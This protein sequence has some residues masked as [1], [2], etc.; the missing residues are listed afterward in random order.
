MYSNIIPWNFEQKI[1]VNVNLVIAN[2]CINKT[3]R[4]SFPLFHFKDMQYLHLSCNMGTPSYE[5]P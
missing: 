4:F 3:E 2:I 5:G 1:V